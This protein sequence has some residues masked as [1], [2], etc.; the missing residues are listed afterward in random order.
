MS[1]SNDDVLEWWRTNERVV[2]Q[3]PEISDAIMEIQ[4]V[5]YNRKLPSDLPVMERGQTQLTL[6]PI[7]PNSDEDNLVKCLNE[8]NIDKINTQGQF[9]QATVQTG[10]ITNFSV[11]LLDWWHQIENKMCD[12]VY[13]SKS[14]QMLDTLENEKEYAKNILE[15]VDSALVAL[16]HLNQG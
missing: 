5:S 7:I 11:E 14:R 8:L 9:F 2:D 13:D 10:L 3:I 15:A 6:P 4:S 16:N 1:S 12:H